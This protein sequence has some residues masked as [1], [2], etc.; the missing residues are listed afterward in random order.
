M[1]ASSYFPIEYK[2]NLLENIFGIASVVWIILAVA[3][4]L[5][6]VVLYYVTKS[7]LKSIELIKDN[8]YRS[9][10]I[11]T[12]AVY[13]IIHPK[14][15]IPVQIEAYETD[16]EID[17]I[18][19]HEEVHI[20]RKDNLFRVVAVIT[21]SVYWFNPL[22]WI[23]LKS[24]FEDMELACDAGV[25][26]NLNPKQTKEYAGAILSYAAGKTFFASAFGGAKTR[27]RIESI[28]SYNRLTLLSSLC[29]GVFVLAIMVVLITNAVA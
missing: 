26:K 1:G 25:I 16:Y 7:E 23:F 13:G 4:V 12:P 14:I 11:T 5:T 20:R 28:L 6:S 24:F 8:I 29:F 18:I 3:S 17:Y 21:A 22:S 9:N 27:L 15:I 2:T 10:K 19:Q